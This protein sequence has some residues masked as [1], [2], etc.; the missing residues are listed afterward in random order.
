MDAQKERDS[1]SFA[2]VTSESVWNN[3]S[4]KVFI[5]EHNTP[6][7]IGQFNDTVV[8]VPNKILL[9]R[10]RCLKQH[11][12]RL[13]I[14]LILKVLVEEKREG[15]DT[16]PRSIFIKDDQCKHERDF[17]VFHLPKCQV[18]YGEGLS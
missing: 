5:L 16:L 6:V 15:R 10:G 2:L 18:K 1:L 13:D 11:L 14:K 4:R 3:R 9:C 12:D 7:P 8:R 17:V